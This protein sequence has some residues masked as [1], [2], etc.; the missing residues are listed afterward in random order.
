MRQQ[1]ASAAKAA[2]LFHVHV[3]ACRCGCEAAGPVKIKSIGY[4]I[5][6]SGTDCHALVQSTDMDK[7]VERWNEM[8]TR[9]G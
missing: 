1:Q 4:Q 8:A 3:H 9:I 5:K 7:A 6:C 2:S